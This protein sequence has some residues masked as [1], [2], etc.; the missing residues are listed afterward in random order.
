[1]ELEQLFSMAG[2]IAMLGWLLLAIL[3]RQPIAQLI[4]GVVLPIALSS[5]TMMALQG[6][7]LLA[8]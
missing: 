3:P 6:R 7:P 8:L 4:A 2:L 1:M 5:D